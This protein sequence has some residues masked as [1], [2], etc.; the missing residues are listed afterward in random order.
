MRRTNALEGKWNL[1]CRE[2]R[3]IDVSYNQKVWK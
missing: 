1:R 2:F 3:S